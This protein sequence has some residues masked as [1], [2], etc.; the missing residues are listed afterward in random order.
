MSIEDLPAKLPLI[1]KWIDD[2][3]SQHA[4]NA[5]LVSTY[6]FPRLPKF[7]SAGLLATAKVVPVD[8]VPVPPLAE[9]GMPEFVAF[10]EGDYSG[11][12]YKDTYFLRVTEAA[13]ES[14]HFHELVHVVQ[15]AHLGVEGF[16]QAYAAG[17][18]AFGYRNSPLEEMAY[19]L[20]QYFDLGNQPDDIEAFVRSKLNELY[21]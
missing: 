18:L 4:A 2:T 12:T 5:R 6:G 1:S 15:W 3:L 21:P 10:V 9:M 14:L 19:R 8:R 17:L 16:L 13:N 7:Y 11:I 20:Q